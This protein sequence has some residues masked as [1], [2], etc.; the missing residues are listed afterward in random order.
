MSEPTIP[1]PPATEPT[2]VHPAGVEGVEVSG[3][4]PTA[5]RTMSPV[6]MEVGR[7]AVTDVVPVPVRVLLGVVP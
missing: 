6:S 2:R 5:N 4:L 1:V 7:P 3:L